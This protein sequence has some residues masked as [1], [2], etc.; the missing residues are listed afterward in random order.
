MSE[1]LFRTVKGHESDYNKTRVNR[2]QIDMRGV[3]FI[4][5]IYR[6]YRD[7]FRS[8]D[9]GRTLWVVIIVK[10]VIIFAVVRLFF[11]P[12]TLSEKAAGGSKADYVS[13]QLTEKGK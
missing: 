6:F 5:H 3:G 4:K 13:T 12:D 2:L 10:I 7:G 9:V 8:M 11:M 1:S